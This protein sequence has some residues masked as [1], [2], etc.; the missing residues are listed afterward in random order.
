[1]MFD[2]KALIRAQKAGALLSPNAIQDLVDGV[3]KGLIPD[4]QV[5]AW[6]MAVYFK[7]ISG[8]NL[9]NFTLAMMKSGR[10]YQWAQDS[11]RG[12]CLDKH[13]TG[14][15]GDKVSFLFAPLAV[16]L[17]FRVPM[18]AGRTLGHTGGTIDK[19][20]SIKGFRTS[21]QGEEELAGAL[22]RCGMFIVGQSEDM[23][24]ADRKLYAL[25]DVTE[26][27][28]QIDLIT[29]S[30][31]SKKVAEGAKAV[32]Y[33]VK[34]GKG[35]FLGDLLAARAL[36]T[37]LIRV[38]RRLELKAKAVITSMSH[39]LGRWV[40]NSV[41]ILEC[42]TIFQDL[43]EGRAVDSLSLPLLE[44][45][46]DLVV[47]GALA[48]GDPRGEGVLKSLCQEALAKGSALEVFLNFCHSQGA[49]PDWQ[50]FLN[51]AP[52]AAE[53]LAPKD[54]YLQLIDAGRVGYAGLLLQMGRNV[55]TDLIAHSHAIEI[56]ISQ[57]GAVKQ[58]EPVMRIFAA[59]CPGLA[60]AITMLE[61]SMTIS[62]VPSL[63]EDLILEK[64]GAIDD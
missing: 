17:G 57:G 2:M 21:L 35:A 40:G 60:K 64:I 59:S 51:P 42:L 28:D 34:C 61:Q 32:V 37:S 48:A 58:G 25:R 45:S 26:T 8:D 47:Q 16:T 24:P 6:L 19:L 54:G 29:A 44:L 43:K 55:Q 49:I 46:M 31:V 9:Y 1:M 12:L 30:I 23:C 10:T 4:Y 22:K 63:P 18:V 50:N 52:L 5:S 41:E 62:L 39:P 3:A 11:E 33:D 36:A 14:G 7:G 20:E 56:L 53:I 15:V 27:V 38:S 13:S